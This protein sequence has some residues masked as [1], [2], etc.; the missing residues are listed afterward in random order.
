MHPHA[1]EQIRNVTFGRTACQVAPARL[2]AIFCAALVIA[3][4]ASWTTECAAAGAPEAPLNHPTTLSRHTLPDFAD[5]VAQ[6]KP[7]VVS[8]TSR[9][10]VGSTEST[11]EADRGQALPFPF[12]Q[13]PF[14]LMVPRSRAVEARASGFIIKADGTIVT[15]NHVVAGAANVMVTLDDG[16]QSSARILGRDPGTDIAVLKISTA[17]PLP[18]L[19]LGDSFSARAGEWVVAM[20]NPFGLGGTATVG[21]ISA[22][23]RDVGAGPYEQFIQVDAPINEGNSGGPL[24]TQDGKVIGMATAILTPSGGSVGIGFAI[25][26]NVIRTIVPQL[27]AAGHIVRGFIGVQTQMIS[28]AL[29]TVLRLP[30]RTGALVAGIELDGPAAR[31]GVAIGDVIRAVNGQRVTTPR[32]LAG[33]VSNVQPGH[34]ARL[35]IIRNGQERSITVTVTALP[36]PATTSATAPT[37]PQEAGLGLALSALSPALRRQLEV[38]EGTGGTVVMTVEP[39]SPADL[40]GIVAGDVIIGVGAAAVN[41]VREATR[42]IRQAQHEGHAVLL[43]VFRDGRAAFVAIDVAPPNKG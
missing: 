28:Q 30:D 33:A 4:V 42:A 3:A 23:G 37:Q 22:Q 7:A 21:I 5:L 16:S 13:F 8:I 17:R 26:S 2:C 31:A 34:Q 36:E 39:G 15:N 18:Y 27:E 24:F 6:V 32:D 19:E 35:D 1:A 10:Q 9:L 41:D 12:N 25:P 40:A 43:R 20:G 11:Q 38:P 29:A 14:N